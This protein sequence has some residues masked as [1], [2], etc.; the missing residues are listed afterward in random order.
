MP[1][2]EGVLL[3]LFGTLVHL[4]PARLPALQVG[5]RAVHSTLV[6][7]DDLLAR[8]APG[9]GPETF[10]LALVAVS[11]ELAQQRARDHLE[12]PSRERFRRA[13]AHVGCAPEVCEEGGAVLARVHHRA[14][15]SAT[16]LP[17]SHAALLDDLRRRHRLAVVSN[18]DDTAGAYE[19][20]HRHGILARVDAVLVSEGFGLRKPH[21]LM[22]DTA[23]RMLD[24]PGAAGVLVGDT[25]A[26]DVLAAH[27]AGIDAAWIDRDG[28]GV[29]EAETPPRF[30]LRA[31]PELRAA[32]AGD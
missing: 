14:L 15:A 19:V 21:P 7:L 13:L 5:S 25:F 30:V 31:L 11:E 27:A 2:Y 16:V 24:V 8:Y 10:W 28:R 12:R 23:L 6:G 20:L 3:D 1:R 22:I 4:E 17:A 29:P 18:F 9:V 32:L 26:E